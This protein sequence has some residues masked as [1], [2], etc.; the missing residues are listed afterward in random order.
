M[1]TRVLWFKSPLWLP[2]YYNV[3][4]FGALENKIFEQ[5]RS[6]NQNIIR[7]Q[8]EDFFLN[9]NFDCLMTFSLKKMSY[10]MKKTP[11]WFAILILA[12][13]IFIFI[14]KNAGGKGRGM[15]QRCLNSFI[16]GFFFKQFL[17]KKLNVTRN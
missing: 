6:I 2:G 17:S 10:Q 15:G 11:S 12:G 16:R 14:E 5:V 3:F 8:C 1:T 9:Q 13:L 7:S 4:P